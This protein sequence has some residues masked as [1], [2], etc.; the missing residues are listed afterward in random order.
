MV[1]WIW[2][3]LGT[4]NMLEN[5]TEEGTIIVDVRDLKDS[6]ENDVA[7][8]AE[9]IQL[10]GNLLCSGYKVVVRCQAGISRSNTIACAVMMWINTEM[11]WDVAWK[12][13]EKS[14]P[15]ARLNMDF[16]DTVKKALIHLAKGYGKIED[17]L[18]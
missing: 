1:Y 10:V 9:K 7:A 2:K 6:G 3:E 13:V 18:I 16:Y 14:C 12:K 15:R 17:R 11:Y 8:V 4:I 5:N